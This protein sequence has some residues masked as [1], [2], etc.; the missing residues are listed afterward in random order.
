MFL[1]EALENYRGVKD[2]DAIEAGCLMAAR[3]LAM[4]DSPYDVKF[5]EIVGTIKIWRAP[6]FLL[7]L[8]RW[9]CM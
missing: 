6:S 4:P 2:D 1:N 3:L 8:H 5:F 7:I 9:N